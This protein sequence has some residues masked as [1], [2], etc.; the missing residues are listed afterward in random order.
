MSSVATLLGASESD[1]QVAAEELWSFE[2]K[3][4]EVRQS[5][6]QEKYNYYARY[7]LLLSLT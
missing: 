4:A 5:T 1:S 3:L 6:Q 2:S 7:A